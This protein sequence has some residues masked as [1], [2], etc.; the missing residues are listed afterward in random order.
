MYETLGLISISQPGF[1]LEQFLFYF[2]ICKL[3]TKNPP[4]VA[5]TTG[6]ENLHFLAN[7]PMFI[8]D[9][10]VQKHTDSAQ[11]PYCDIYIWQHFHDCMS[12][13]CPDTHFM[14]LQRTM[15]L[16]CYTCCACDSSYC[17]LHFSPTE[18]LVYSALLYRQTPTTGIVTVIM[19]HR[20]MALS[21]LVTLTI[22]WFNC[23]SLVA[24]VPLQISWFCLMPGYI[25]L[26]W[27]S[28]CSLRNE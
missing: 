7:F 16:F 8:I 2:R 21:E 28:W 12:F 15:C 19:V 10:N 3:R 14:L 6:P 17:S 27:W 4:A 20:I 22:L 11:F 23:N 24:C 13:C 9:R 26:S 1:I 5:R 18:Q 25:S